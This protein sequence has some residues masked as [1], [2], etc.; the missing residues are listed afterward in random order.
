MFKKGQSGN[1]SG[2]PKVVGQIRDIARE[3]GPAAFHRIIQL[4]ASEDERVA[5]AASQEVLNRAYGKPAQALTGEDGEGPA[6][7][8]VEIVRFGDQASS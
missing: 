1:P 5:L 8:V 2:R 7:L 4:M 3:H 6:K